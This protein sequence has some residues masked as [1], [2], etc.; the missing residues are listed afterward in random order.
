MLTLVSISLTGLAMASKA[1]EAAIRSLY[2][3]RDRAFATKDAKTIAATQHPNFYA[4]DPDGKDITKEQI[5]AYL[6]FRFAGQVQC[7][8]TEKPISFI[9]A[10]DRAQVTLLVKDDFVIQDVAGIRT[11]DQR[12]EHGVAT[13][14]REKKKWR[15]AHFRF[16]KVEWVD[17]SGVWRSR[18][19]KKS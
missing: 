16:T 18:V 8:R 11:R 13:W 2:K 1:D 6:K 7:K 15:L 3:A 5:S 17:K 12:R 14:V 9:F 10:G 19:G 4:T